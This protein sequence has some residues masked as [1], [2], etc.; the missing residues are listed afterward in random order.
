MAGCPQSLSP[1]S[2]CTV[3]SQRP[4]CAGF[5]R[6]KLKTNASMESLC[7][8]A[9]GWR[10]VFLPPLALHPTL[11]ENKLIIHVSTSLVFTPGLNVSLLFLFGK[12]V[13]FC[14]L[15]MM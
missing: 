14:L 11:P 15:L 3:S 7:C 4:T 12:I 1:F 9:E 13:L 6:T 2:R 8:D 10:V 5:W